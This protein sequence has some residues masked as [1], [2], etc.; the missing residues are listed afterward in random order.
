MLPAIHKTDGY[1]RKSLEETVPPLPMGP[2]DAECTAPRRNCYKLLGKSLVSPAQQSPPSSPLGSMYSSRTSSKMSSKVNSPLSS[3]CPSKERPSS[4]L[5]TAST[6]AS[7]NASSRSCSKR[8]SSL[9]GRAFTAH[10]ASHDLRSFSLSRNRRS[11]HEP[12]SFHSP[13]VLN[14]EELLFDLQGGNGSHK[15]LQADDEIHRRAWLQAEK[16]LQAQHDQES[17]R[18]L[19]KETTEWLHRAMADKE[20]MHEKIDGKARLEEEKEEKQRAMDEEA[21]LEMEASEAKRKRLQQPRQCFKCSGSGKCSS[22][23]GSGCHTVTY[24]SPNAGACSQA[25]RGRTESG[26]RLCGGR[27]DGAELLELAVLKGHG[28]C[29]TCNGAGEIVPAKGR[30]WLPGEWLEGEQTR[31]VGMDSYRSFIMSRHSTLKKGRTWLPGEWLEAE[32]TR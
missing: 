8:K 14:M 11:L 25:F 30:T 16:E 18:Q 7:S 19:Q 13:P 5:S 32:E 10:A 4:T 15:K 31:S 3:R 28:R 1:F 2:R 23:S 24:L 21:R 22:C 20:E 12:Q 26:C 17:R 6:T 29:E 27:Q 9:G